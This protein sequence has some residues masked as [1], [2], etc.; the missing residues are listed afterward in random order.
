MIEAYT[1]GGTDPVSAHDIYLA[2]S[3]S[4]GKARFGKAGMTLVLSMED[5]VAR[6]LKA[7]WSEFDLGG[8]ATWGNK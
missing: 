3:E 6:M 4:V 1:G 5:A 2:I 7:D 8:V